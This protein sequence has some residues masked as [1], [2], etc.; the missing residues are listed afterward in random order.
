MANTEPLADF[1]TRLVDVEG[2]GKTV[3]VAGSG[4]AV[5]LMPDW[6]GWR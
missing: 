2:V 3:H 5:V 6:P 1:T 4:P